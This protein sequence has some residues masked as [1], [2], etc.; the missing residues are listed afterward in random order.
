MNA[1]RLLLLADFLEKLPRKRFNYNTWVGDSWEGAKD[2]S[3]GTTAC[4]LGWAATIP[5][6]R[7]AGLELRQSRAGNGYVAL[8]GKRVSEHNDP[9]F[10]AAMHVFDICEDDVHY[11]FTPYGSRLLPTVGP[12]AVAKH[13]RRYVAYQLKNK[14]KTARASLAR[15]RN[16]PRPGVT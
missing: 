3:C 11:L 8:R 4:A 15:E 5:I 1:R 10:L 13:I 6:L 2:L 16:R 12:K 9:S 7:R 14:A